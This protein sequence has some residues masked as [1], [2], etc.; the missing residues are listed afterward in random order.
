M[1]LDSF[2]IAINNPAIRQNAWEIIM[3]NA[4][5]FDVSREGSRTVLHAF[6]SGGNI[7]LGKKIS[8][9]LGNYPI[10]HWAWKVIVLPSGGR[11][12]VKKKND[13]AAGII[14]GL[15]RGFAFNALKYVWSS[16]LPVG[17]VVRDG[18]GAYDRVIV[19]E[20][21][22]S[23]TGKWI[24]EKV[25]FGKD[26]RRCF[27]D[28]YSGIQGVSIMTDSDNTR[29]SAEAYYADLSFSTDSLN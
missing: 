23:R 8:V 2:V 11:E 21:G 6:T 16:T 4:Q 24:S 29:S 10:L 28:R 13:S 19:L 3:G 14:I 12:D 22:G 5:M 27:D 18:P 9:P 20:S 7:C 1:G 26:I 25:D 15:K 17:S